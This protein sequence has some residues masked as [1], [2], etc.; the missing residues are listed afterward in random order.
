MAESKTKRWVP[1]KLS[2]ND[3]WVDPPQFPSHIF[4]GS[5]KDVSMGCK[6]PE[7]KC[8]LCEAGY[9]PK[10]TPIINTDFAQLELRIVA[11]RMAEQGFKLESPQGRTLIPMPMMHTHDDAVYQVPEEGDRIVG[12]DFGDDGRTVL[13]MGVVKRSGEP[14]AN[15]DVF[16]LE[17]MKFLPP[18]QSPPT[19]KADLEREPMQ[20]MN[21]TAQRIK[22]MTDQYIKTYQGDPHHVSQVDEQRF[23][24]EYLCQPLDPGD[25][26]GPMKIPKLDEHSPIEKIRWVLE[27]ISERLNWL[28]T[29]ENAPKLIEVKELSREQYTLYRAQ[30]RVEALLHQKEAEMNIDQLAGLYASDD[31]EG[32][33]PEKVYCP[34]CDAP[35]VLHEAGR[36]LMEGHEFY[37]CSNYPHCDATRTINEV[38]EEWPKQWKV[39]VSIVNGE[40]QS[41][42]QF[43]VF[44]GWRWQPLMGK[45]FHK[46]KISGGHI[47][48][49]FIEPAARA[50]GCNFFTMTRSL[51]EA[52]GTKNAGVVAKR[53][54]RTIGAIDPIHAVDDIMLDRVLK[55]SKIVQE[56]LGIKPERELF[57][58]CV[59]RRNYKKNGEDVLQLRAKDRKGQTIKTS[60]MPWEH[61]DDTY[62]TEALIEEFCHAVAA[63]LTL[64]SGDLAGAQQ[65]LTCLRESTERVKVTSHTFKHAVQ[66]IHQV[67][68][69][70]SFGTKRGSD[71]TPQDINKP[72]KH[73]PLTSV[74]LSV[75]HPCT[76]RKNREIELMACGSHA[77]DYFQVSVESVELTL[78]RAKQFIINFAQKTA[79]KFKVAAT[80]VVELVEDRVKRS[81]DVL[82]LGEQKLLEQACREILGTDEPTFSEKSARA[83]SPD[84]KRFI[85]EQ[86]RLAPQKEKERQ[87]RI[88][89]AQED[90]R[91]LANKAKIYKAGYCKKCDKTGCMCPR[92]FDPF[93]PENHPL[94]SC[95]DGIHVRLQDVPNH[96]M[97]ELDL[98]EGQWEICLDCFEL[99]CDGVPTGR[100]VST[101]DAPQDS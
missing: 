62:A 55:D 38:K 8:P 59:E 83:W 47:F 5:L 90:A 19:T 37:G 95:K 10:D 75:G 70:M 69:A 96:M 14:D 100:R 51:L 85:E 86:K 36:G 31:D 54:V 82:L 92:P 80:R 88:H 73:G 25:E 45:R 27:G 9:E 39:V 68:M 26:P 42:L 93:A 61:V 35:M 72:L 89:K 79:A 71:R 84:T 30:Q 13:V 41:R 94:H 7:T 81:S 21:K 52:L 78:E 3:I 18:G 98:D 91:K 29:S 22:A 2:F 63:E 1:G 65:V 43:G 99:H 53:M 6:V 66:A 74:V 15:G 44:Y 77:K 24:N 17:D 16:I 57:R 4:D 60:Q 34:R 12:I 101:L 48:H 50:V 58:V 32:D 40:Q 33:L 23:A 56:F 87:E 49:D 11:Q 97:A 76:E 67:A 28:A 46:T 64:G 20:V